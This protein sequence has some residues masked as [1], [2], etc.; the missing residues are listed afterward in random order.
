MSWTIDA[1]KNR[2]YVDHILGD[3]ADNRFQI[4][5]QL[6]PGSWQLTLRQL[7]AARTRQLPQHLLAAAQKLLVLSA[8]R[9]GEPQLITNTN[10]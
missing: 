4:W 6:A 3:N 1:P 8:S 2:V 7:A 10:K 5:E 9:L